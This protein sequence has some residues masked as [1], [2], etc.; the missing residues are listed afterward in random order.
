MQYEADNFEVPKSSASS[1]CLAFSFDMPTFDMEMADKNIGKRRWNAT[2]KRCEKPT[3]I[4][5]RVEVTCKE[6]FEE[7]VFVFVL[8]ARAFVVTAEFERGDLSYS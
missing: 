2:R 4:I 3:R 5:F 8:V 1:S 7:R 6:F